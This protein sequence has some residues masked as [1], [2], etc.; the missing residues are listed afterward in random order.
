MDIVRRKVKFG[1][2][3]LLVYLDLQILGMIELS[4]QTI[5]IGGSMSAAIKMRMR[6]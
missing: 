3:I 6:E 1:S 4:E 5:N 2:S